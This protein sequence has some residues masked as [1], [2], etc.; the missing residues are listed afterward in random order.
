MNPM[1]NVLEMETTKARS[2]VY[3]NVDKVVTLKEGCPHC[4]RGYRRIHIKAFVKD[5]CVVSN[6]VLK[7][8]SHRKRCCW[9]CK[10]KPQIGETWGMT[11]S[12][13]EANR[14]FCP[15]CSDWLES[16]YLKRRFDDGTYHN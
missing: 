6:A 3:N 7:M 12:Y 10:A 2:I 4:K 8:W 14:L 1:E 5:L 15:R 16:E 13:K 11:L 9:K